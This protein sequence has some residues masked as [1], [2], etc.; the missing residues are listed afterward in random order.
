MSRKWSRFPC[1]ARTRPAPRRNPDATATAASGLVPR[2]RGAATSQLGAGTVP[3][4]LG[5]PAY[6]TTTAS[7]SPNVFRFR[8]RRVMTGGIPENKA[9]GCP[10]RCF[11]GAGQGINPPIR[12]SAAFPLSRSTCPDTDAASDKRVGLPE[13]KPGTGLRTTT[14]G[15]TSPSLDVASQHRTGAMGGS[16]CPRRLQ[17]RP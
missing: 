6:R 15:E 9:P 2:Q 11:S 5:P 16:R 7:P 3:V 10:K 8:A 17:C 1:P 13:A 12:V 14:T 4:P